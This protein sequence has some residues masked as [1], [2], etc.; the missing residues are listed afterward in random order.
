MKTKA[1]A[2]EP[3]KRFVTDNYT[4]QCTDAISGTVGCF[5]YDVDKW[6][7]TGKFF[8]VAPVYRDLMDFFQAT[9]PEDIKKR[10]VEFKG[11]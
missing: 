1:K 2:T 7:T 5:L 11:E 10:Y 6:A 3:A 9:K 8:A 4:I